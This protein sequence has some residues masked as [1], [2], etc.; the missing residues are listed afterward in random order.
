MN[1]PRPPRSS[2]RAFA[3]PLVVILTAVLGVVIGYMLA[4]QNT[5]ALTVE[6]QINAYR[7]HHNSRGMQE[8]IGG[9]LKSVRS[10]DASRFLG[11]D[12]KVLDVELPGG[13]TLS[14]YMSDGQGQ[15]LD[16]AVA[17]AD[18]AFAETLLAQ[19][20][21][22]TPTRTF[23]S[24]Q[25]SI[26]S[27]PQE[28]LVALAS[29]ATDGAHGADFAAAVISA[30]QSKSIPITEVDNIAQSVGFTPEQLQELTRSITAEPQVWLIETRLFPGTGPAFGGRRDPQ[31]FKAYATLG[32]QNRTVASNITSI[33]SQRSSIHDW[34]E[35]PPPRGPD[36]VGSDPD[37]ASK[38][39]N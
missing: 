31:T 19:A 3:L 10:N 1:T 26:N 13:G 38:A 22:G 6:R 9:Y 16:P 12:G 29:R 28:A 15:L 2:R 35:V 8:L 11:P 36:G 34:K 14:V 30:R 33:W 37:A 18:R 4:R 39:G 27:A 32:T 25:V 21:E 5:Q 24:V 23:G 7:Q 17:G 20:P